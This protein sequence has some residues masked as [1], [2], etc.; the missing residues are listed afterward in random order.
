MKVGFDATGEVRLVTSGASGSPDL[1]RP[2]APGVR[3]NV[4]GFQQPLVQGPGPHVTP[5]SPQADT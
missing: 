1:T 2:D 4:L 5:I 3:G